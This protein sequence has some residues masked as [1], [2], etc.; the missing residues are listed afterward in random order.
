MPY[1]PRRRKMLKRKLYGRKRKY[2]M[3]RRR[4]GFGKK[5]HGVKYFTE[6][7]PNLLN[8]TS[9]AAPAENDY[10]CSVSYNTIPNF[11][12]YNGLFKQFAILGVKLIYKPNYNIASLI[13]GAAGI[14]RMFFVEDKMETGVRQLLQFLHKIIVK[15]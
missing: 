10:N 2:G 11:P 4:G 3:R 14:P 15:Y 9:P 5:Y 7:I 12:I 8:I 13:A 6:T 1:Y